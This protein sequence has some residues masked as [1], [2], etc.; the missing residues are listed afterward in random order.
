MISQIPTNKHTSSL[1]VINPQP[2]VHFCIQ[3][4]QP[5]RRS[6]QQHC[7]LIMSACHEFSIFVV[8]DHAIDK[9][10]GEHIDVH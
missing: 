6:L 3:V 4:T 5:I 1:G 2:N 10:I 8:S 9:W 7:T